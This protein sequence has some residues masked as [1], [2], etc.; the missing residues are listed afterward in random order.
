MWKLGRNFFLF[1][2]LNEF[3][4]NLFFELNLQHPTCFFEEFVEGNVMNILN[5]TIFIKF[6]LYDLG[7][8]DSISK[9]QKIK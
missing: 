2:F 8:E 1:F 4:Y 7:L 3:V 6:K 5:K 9:E